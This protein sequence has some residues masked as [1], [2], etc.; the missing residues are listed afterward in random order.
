MKTNSVTIKYTVG[1]IERSDIR[2]GCHPRS[3]RAVQHK[4]MQ[5]RRGVPVI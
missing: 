4:V 3:P 1:R 2:A 5:R